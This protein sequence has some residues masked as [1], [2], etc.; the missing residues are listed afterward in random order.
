MPSSDHLFNDKHNKHN[1][2]T[3]R[4]ERTIKKGIMQMLKMNQQ[5]LKYELKLSTM[6]VITTH[7]CLSASRFGSFISFDFLQR[8][9]KNP[10]IFKFA[11]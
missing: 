3:M 5:K 11:T 6:N 10:S 2:T 1:V 4:S 9:I 7:K 8:T